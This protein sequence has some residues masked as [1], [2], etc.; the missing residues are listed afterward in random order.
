MDFQFKPGI[1]PPSTRGSAY[2]KTAA[3]RFAAVLP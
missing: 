3:N 2:G 1:R